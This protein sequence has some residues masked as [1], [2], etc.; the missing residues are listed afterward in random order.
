M[1]TL[2][3][4]PYTLL[5]LAGLSAYDISGSMKPRPRSAESRGSV[6]SIQDSAP[7]IISL[8]KIVGMQIGDSPIAPV[9]KVLR[10]QSHTGYY[11]PHILFYD[12]NGLV[13]QLEEYKPQIIRSYKET[14]DG[15][16]QLAEITTRLKAVDLKILNTGRY[17]SRRKSEEVAYEYET[18][19]MIEQ[20]TTESFIDLQNGRE[21]LAFPTNA[22]VLALSRKGTALYLDQDTIYSI[23]VN[24]SDPMRTRRIVYSIPQEE[25]GFVY[26]FFKRDN[27]VILRLDHNRCLEIN[28]ETGTVNDITHWIQRT[29]LNL[30]MLF[31]GWIPFND[32]GSFYI[33]T[34]GDNCPRH[35]Q[36]IEVYDSENKLVAS[37]TISHIY[38]RRYRPKAFW[39]GEREFVVC[40]NQYAFLYRIE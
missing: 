12:D 37:T 16:A 13:V 15:F 19:V 22:S 20:E 34:P 21:A 25:S 40:L 23:N 17:L 38:G 35:D 36:V 32:S 31:G 26:A 18:G 24:D 33:R 39:T 1:L 14:T 4:M 2:G 8:K 7:L 10:V 3:K 9:D 5:F 30:N 28:L 11:P 29:G 6:S 27:T